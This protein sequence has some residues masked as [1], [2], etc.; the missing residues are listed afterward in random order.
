M[1]VGEKAKIHIS[2][3]HTHTAL[4]LPSCPSMQAMPSTQ[5][6]F[7]TTIPLHTRKTPPPPHTQ[8]IKI[9]PK[10]DINGKSSKCTRRDQAKRGA[11]LDERDA[12]QKHSHVLSLYYIPF[13]F[14]F[15]FICYYCNL[16]QQICFHNK[17]RK[18]VDEGFFSLLC[19][20]GFRFCFGFLLK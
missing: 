2:R 11:V 3:L 13:G 4:V 9:L 7:A 12:V 5:P 15:P 19:S 16:G 14:L 17:H 8:S 10:K 6:P 20:C 18:G 1:V